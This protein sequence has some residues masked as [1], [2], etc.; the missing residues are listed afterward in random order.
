MSKTYEEV[1]DTLQST[2]KDTA[3]KWASTIEGFT[4]TPQTKTIT[5]DNWNTLLELVGRTDA[6]IRAT[7][8]LVMGLGNLG[9]AYA[10]SEIESGNVS[11]EGVLSLT[12]CDGKSFTVEG[13]IKGP[14]GP[15]G[16]PFLISK[17]FSSVAEMLNGA[18]SDGVL[19]GQYVAIDTN[20]EFEDSAKVFMKNKD[21][22]Y[23]FVVDL[24]GKEGIQGP[25]GPEG[26]EG[27]I[28]PVGPQGPAGNIANVELDP[29]W[30]TLNN[31]LEDGH[32]IMGG[33]IY[34]DM[35]GN[36][37]VYP[38]APAYGVRKDEAGRSIPAVV[39]YNTGQQV[40][41]KP[42]TDGRH[43][44]SLQQLDKFFGG[45]DGTSEKTFSIK[46]VPPVDT[47]LP[48]GQRKP[49]VFCRDSSNAFA[50]K[51]YD[52][53][54]FARSLAERDENGNIQLQEPTRHDHAVTLEYFNSHITP[55]N[56]VMT[57]DSGGVYFGGVLT[58]GELYLVSVIAEHPMRD[59]QRAFTTA[60]RAGFP[61]HIDSPD[62]EFTI[63]EDTVSYRDPD[64]PITVVFT[65][66]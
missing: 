61:V 11:P 13:N 3:E 31:S 6:C 46:R 45:T 4:K 1:L 64:Y 54:P 9:A 34:K 15:Q 22:K 19:P 12:R 51:H 10:R 16:T 24:S 17:T 44:V 37:Q 63:T 8:A 21:G 25:E 5:L 29:D 30:Y 53:L 57:S 47:S 39:V 59:F 20:V 23:K 65:K 56:I 50:G 35:D 28:G 62:Q 41:C 2:F 55:A 58:S 60:F 42:A 43:A 27:P 40:M 18:A 7:Y 36:P 32:K 38:L 66:L 26:P 52:V 48:I 33:L 49:Y 14:Q